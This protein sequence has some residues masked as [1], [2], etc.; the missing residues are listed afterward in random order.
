MKKMAR[1][2]VEPRCQG[3]REIMIGGTFAV[4]FHGFLVSQLVV[5]EGL[6]CELMFFDSHLDD[7]IAEATTMM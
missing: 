4:L 7:A 1:Q 2:P 5:G 6:T 3:R